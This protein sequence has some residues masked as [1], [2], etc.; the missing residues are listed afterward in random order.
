VSSFLGREYGNEI[1][2]ACSRLPD[3]GLKR[4]RENKTHGIWRKGGGGGK[5]ALVSPNAF[6]AFSFAFPIISE[7]LGEAK[8]W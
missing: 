8:S 5:E 6:F 3:S 1:C 2:L 7:R 4:D